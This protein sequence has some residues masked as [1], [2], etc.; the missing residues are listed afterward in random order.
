MNN[1]NSGSTIKKGILKK[2][3]YIDLIQRKNQEFRENLSGKYSQKGSTRPK[4]H[5]PSNA[6]SDHKNYNMDTIKHSNQNYSHS[7]ADKY[8]PRGKNVKFVEE[9]IVLEVE[10]FKRLNKENYTSKE[11]TSCMCVLL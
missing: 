5:N 11:T 9:P 6:H 7:N 1:N 3:N 8:N 2:K 10:N 4:D